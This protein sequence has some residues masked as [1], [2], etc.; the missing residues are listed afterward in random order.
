MTTAIQNVAILGGSGFVGTQLANR[1]AKVGLEIRALTRRRERARH[2]LVIPTLKLIEADTDSLESLQACLAGCDAVINLIGILNERGDNGRGFQAAHVALV[3]RLVGACKANGIDR[4]LHMSALG[5]QVDA[6]SYYLRSKAA[7]EDY[8]HASA[9]A[10]TSFRPSVIFGPGDDFLN[11]FAALLRNIPGP[12][13]LAC[14]SSRFAPVYVQ[15]VAEAIARSLADPA[16]IG[17]RYD[18]CGPRI[19]TLK[20]LVT[21]TS[22]CVGVRRSI[23]SIPNGLA[24]LQALAMEFVPG[25]PFSRDNYRSLQVDSVCTEGDGAAALG[26]HP[27]GLEAIAPSYLSRHRGGRYGAL[28]RSR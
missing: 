23:I 9:L 14:A 13:P 24:R 8:A 18:L 12:F 3:E 26:I 25:K 19:Y 10:V 7:G 15:D 2:L 21:Y 11:R 20:Q 22:S 27:T 17:A 4:L 16:T 5:A 28:R 6:P 1:L